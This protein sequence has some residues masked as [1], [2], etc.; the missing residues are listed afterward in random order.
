MNIKII[1]FIEAIYLIY[2]FHLM[3]TSVDLGLMSFNGY[4]LKHAVGNIKTL[5]ICPFGRII[6]IPFIIILI[7]RNYVNISNKIVP[8]CALIAFFLSLMNTN[9]TVYLLPI[10]AIELFILYV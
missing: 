7:L 1:S 4:W 6:I 2:T 10:F 3:K 9:A 8:I 5:R